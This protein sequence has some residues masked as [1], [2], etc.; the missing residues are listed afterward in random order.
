MSDLTKELLE[1]L[2]AFDPKWKE[3]YQSIAEAARA[4]DVMELYGNWL[5][6]TD[7][8][9]YLEAVKELRDYVGESRREAEAMRAPASLPFGYSNLG[10]LP[11][12]AWASE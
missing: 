2:E 1:E 10:W 11:N 8:R 6:S 7:G 9:K 5:L 3:H 12:S 4:G